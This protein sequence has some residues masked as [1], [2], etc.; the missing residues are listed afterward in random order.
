MP[1]FLRL[2]VLAVFLL[3]F[4]AF[5]FYPYAQ[6]FEEL[7]EHVAALLFENPSGYF[8]LVVEGGVFQ[9]VE[10][11]SGTAGFGVH[12]AYNYLRDAGLD[13]GAGTHLAGFQCDVHGAVFQAPV[14]YFFAGFVDGC[15]F[16]VGQGVFVGVA[17]VVA[18]AYDFVLVDD[19]AAYRDFSQGVGFFCLGEGGFHVFFL[20][21]DG[22]SHGGWGS[23]LWVGLG[24]GLCWVGGWEYN[25]WG[26]W[27]LAGFWVDSRESAGY[28][29][30]MLRMP[31][32]CGCRRMSVR[33]WK[34]V[35]EQ[36][37]QRF[38]IFLPPP[39]S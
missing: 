31:K 39:G 1:F 8:Y 34:I 24:L 3:A 7:G 25:G 21:G 33:I 23:F 6:F 14:A 27:S 28:S 30:G 16:G 35:G 10:D 4:P 37:P 18:P 32:L 38:S 11:G 9:D 22:W 2:L 19:D 12:A 36:A 29:F 26:M 20:W 13:D 15:Y 17:A 5:F